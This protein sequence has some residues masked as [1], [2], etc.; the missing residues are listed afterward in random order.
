MS[1]T[2]LSERLGQLGLPTRITALSRIEL[3]QRGVNVEELVLVAKVLGV[4]VLDFLVDPDSQFEREASPVAEGFLAAVS[5][6]MRELRRLD[7][8]QQQAWN[9]VVAFAAHGED[10]FE[11]M[12]AVLNKR[13]PDD[14]DQDYVERLAQEVQMV[15]DT[16]AAK[17]VALDQNPWSNTN[18]QGAT[19]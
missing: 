1:L 9:E 7:R 17:T 13:T 2:T 10:Q 18:R 16:Q 4:S 5:V 15:K 8:D 6:R 19:G 3:G 14:G 12:C 11:A